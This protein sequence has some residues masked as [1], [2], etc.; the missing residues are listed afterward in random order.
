MPLSFALALFVNYAFGFSINRVTLFA[1]I[2][3]LG[4][5]VDDP[6]INVDNIQRHIRTGRRNPLSATLFAVQE[7][8]PPVLM[9]TLAIIVSF[10]PLFFIT[11][12]MGPYMAPMA[13]NVPLTVSFSTL[14]TFRW[15]PGSAICC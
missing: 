15:Y 5:V 3:S 2:L 8:L 9:S 7:V 11:G 12:M 10:V 4:L 13:A 1:L 6:I 14:C